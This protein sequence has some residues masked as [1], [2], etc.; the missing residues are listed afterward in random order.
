LRIITLYPDGR[1]SYSDT[2]KDAFREG[3]CTPE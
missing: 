2:D 3:V 1:F